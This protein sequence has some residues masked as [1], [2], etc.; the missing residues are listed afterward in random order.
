MVVAGL[1]FGDRPVTAAPRLLGAR[2]VDQSCAPQ[3][4]SAQVRV[5]PAHFGLTRGLAALRTEPRRPTTATTDK[6]DTA[7][8]AVSDVHFHVLTCLS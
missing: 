7:F 6:L 1:H 5:Q 3:L 4:Q 2:P 8:H